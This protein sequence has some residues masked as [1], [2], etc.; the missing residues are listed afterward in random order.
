VCVS[1]SLDFGLDVEGKWTLP[2]VIVIE[3][4]GYAIDG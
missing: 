3:M 1:W 2:E 4:I